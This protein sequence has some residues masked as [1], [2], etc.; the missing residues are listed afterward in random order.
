MLSAWPKVRIGAQWRDSHQ[1]G[2]FYLPDLQAGS[3]FL[4]HSCPGSVGFVCVSTKTVR[5]SYAG[6]RQG[7]GSQCPRPPTL[8]TVGGIRTCGPIPGLTE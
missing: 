3:V 5:L 2:L 7:I 8:F 4:A 6:Y 1:Y